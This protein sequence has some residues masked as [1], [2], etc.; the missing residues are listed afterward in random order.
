[1]LLSQSQKGYVFSLYILSELKVAKN[2]E[3]IKK[4]SWEYAKVK[5]ASWE[6]NRESKYDEY[7]RGGS[8]K[9]KNIG[10]GD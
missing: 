9:R 3:N 1:M 6:Y 4:N 7:M 2:P 5:Q 10:K 8:K